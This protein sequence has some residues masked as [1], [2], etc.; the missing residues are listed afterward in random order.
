[1]SNTVT[2]RT[3]GLSSGG[4]SALIARS[5]DGL[6]TAVTTLTLIIFWISFEPFAGDRVTQEVF[7]TATSG[8]LINQLGFTALFGL[9]LFSML[10]FTPPAA[11]VR[12]L[13]FS[14]MVVIVML[15]VSVVFAP[16][17]NAAMRAFLFTTFTLLTA[18]GLCVLPKNADSFC[19]SILIAGGAVLVLSYVGVVIFP[20]QAI[21]QPGAIEAQHTG[22]W[23][24]VFT[25]KNIAGPIMA[26]LTFAGIYMFRR[27]MRGWGVLFTLAAFVFVLK[28]GS[29]TSAALV[30]AVILMV[31]IPAS[32]G[33]RAL[34][35]FIVTLAIVGTHALTIG[36][37]Y[38]P[39]FDDILRIF[40]STTT[41]TGRIEIWTFAKDYVTQ[42]PLTGFG[43]DG[44]WRTPNSLSAELAFDQTW[45]PR[46]MIHGH[47]GFLDVAL[48]FGLL[49]LALVIWL[50][51]FAPAIAYARTKRTPE[52]G[53]MADFFY[54]IIAF[55][56]MNA[57]LESFYFQRSDPVWLTLV[58]AAFGLRLTSRFSVMSR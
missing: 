34:G 33:T 20:A 57:A 35:A 16:D 43:F 54:M 1:M 37:V 55:T 9:V 41:Y 56:G 4:L 51:V 45:D 32:L 12:L 2:H 36:T 7:G 28:T 25:H 42:N 29:K 10:S 15:G 11:I 48:H 49:C 46:N 8:N 3:D 19:R 39:F 30:P 21:H 18:A 53:Y 38:V 27:G 52:N 5:R 31:L 13:S 44:F 23:R 24:G 58:I 50:L 14:W 47:N 17:T 26:T 40:S 6:R 22:L